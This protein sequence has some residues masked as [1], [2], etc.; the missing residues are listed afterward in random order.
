MTAHHALLW[1]DHSEARVFR[2]E[3]DEV[4]KFDVKTKK[5]DHHAKGQGHTSHQFFDTVV[6]NVRDAQRLL[7]V[8]PGNAKLEFIRYLHKS[9]HAVEEKVVGVETVDHP[10]DGEL[11]KYARHY[12]EHSDRMTG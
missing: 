3:G 6:A 4:S 10:S 1:L 11:V 5:H 9:A 8:G 2:F 7:I 12:F